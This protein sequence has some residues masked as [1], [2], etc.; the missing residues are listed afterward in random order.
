MTAIKDIKSIAIKFI[1]LLLAVM[2]LVPFVAFADTAKSGYIP[3]SSLTYSVVN[4]NSNKC[5]LSISG[6]GGMPSIQG[7]SFEAQWYSDIANLSITDIVVSDG[8]TSISSNIFKD[9]TNLNTIK[10]PDSV[11]NIADDAFPQNRQ[12]EMYAH[13]N[14]C[15]GRYAESHPNIQLKLEELRVLRIGNS[16][17]FLN[18]SSDQALCSSLRSVGLDTNIKI[19]LAGNSAGGHG[20]FKTNAYHSRCTQINHIT[21]INACGANYVAKLQ[22]KDAWDVIVVQDWMESA[23]QCTPDE[24]KNGLQRVVDLLHDSSRQPGAKIAWF[25]DWVDKESASKKPNMGIGARDGYSGTVDECYENSKACVEAVE[26]AGV[27]DFVIPGC[28]VIRDA[29]QTYLGNGNDFAFLSDSTHVNSKG[30]YLVSACIAQSILTEYQDMLILADGRDSFSV[31]D[32]SYTGAFSAADAACANRIAEVSVSYPNRLTYALINSIPYDSLSEAISAAHPGDTVEILGQCASSSDI[33]IPVGV[34]LKMYN[35]SGSHT[36]N[37]TSGGKITSSGITVFGPTFVIDGKKYNGDEA[38]FNG[39]TGEIEVSVVVECATTSNTDGNMNTITG[40]RLHDDFSGFKSDGDK[41]V[42][43]E[44]YASDDGDKEAQPV[45]VRVKL[46]HEL[47]TKRY[48]TSQTVQDIEPDTPLEYRADGTYAKGKV[49]IAFGGSGAYYMP[50]FNKNLQSSANDV[51]GT[52]EQAF[53]DYASW[54]AGDKLRAKETL[55]DGT[56]GMWVEHSARAI[57]ESS[58]MTISDYKKACESGSAPTNVWVYDKDGYYY[59]AA[60]LQ[61][62][63]VTG[64]LIDSAHVSYSGGWDYNLNVEGAWAEVDEP[65]IGAD[66]NYYFDEQATMPCSKDIYDMLKSLTEDV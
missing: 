44:N 61:P 15:A 47:S 7:S 20:L 18:T 65:C 64:L 40:A 57:P 6:T 24:F 42:Y 39:A 4:S 62:E 45:L 3:N 9:C 33:D 21:G 19:E 10:V 12:F 49:D 36:L 59:W 53:V 38:T 1:M 54:K 63:E 48:S 30:N 11:T 35:A 32:T 5:T 34:T 46:S 51:R 8:V 43:F 17:T 56:E 27:V 31:S 55:Y 26:Q 22:A 28:T 13:M 50:T 66:G 14:S 41:N 60:L 25:A 2:L 58:V 52:Y 29:G 23:S 37:L 16:H